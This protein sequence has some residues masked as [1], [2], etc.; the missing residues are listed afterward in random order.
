M[1]R[2]RADLICTKYFVSFVIDF[3]HLVAKRTTS[4]LTQIEAIIKLCPGR[5]AAIQ[6]EKA[7]W[8]QNNIIGILQIDKLESMM[9]ELE[10]WALLLSNRI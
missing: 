9:I 1:P 4:E 6:G 8:Q 3:E 7:K 5:C 10:R 2:Q